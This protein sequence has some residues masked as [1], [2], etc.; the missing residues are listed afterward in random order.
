MTARELELCN[1][2]RSGLSSKEIATLTGVSVATVTT[3][4]R[5]IRRKLG[6]TKTGTNLVTWLKSV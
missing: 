5:S 2:L 1:L 6:L 3:H 4:R